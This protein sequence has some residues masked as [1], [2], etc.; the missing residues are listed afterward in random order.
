[1]KRIYLLIISLFIIATSF[2][3]NDSIIIEKSTD[4]VMIGGELYYV[5]IVKKGETLFS[6]SRVY[7]VSQKDIA[8]DNPE[9]FL[10]L[11]LG[12]A[13]KIPI[14][15]NK[16]AELEDENSFTYHKV[17]KGQTLYS[18]SKKYNVAQEDIIAC[19]PTVRYGINIDQLIKI[20]KSKQIAQAMQKFPTAD[21]QNDTLRISDDFLYHTVQKKETVYS[22][23]RQYEITEDIL[24]E[25]NP[26]A[27]EGL[28]IDQVLKIPKVIAIE[29]QTVLFKQDTAK[30]DTIVFKERAT[31]A[32][33]DTVEKEECTKLWENNLEPY[34]VALM[35]PFY[36]EK[37]DEEFYIDSSEYNDDGEK[38]YERVYYSPYYIYPRSKRFIEFYEGILLSIDSLK[39]IGLSVNVNVYDTQNDTARVQEILLDP[40]LENMDL[41]IG[42]IYDH[43]IKL[44]SEFSKEH[45]IKMVSPLS[46]NLKFVD[47]NPYL[48]Q[49]YP[50][51][52]AQIEEFAKYVSNYQDQNIIVVHSG[53]SLAYE[54]IQMVKNRIFSY[55]S[56]DT[57]VNNIQFKEVVFKDSIN[58]L[59]HALDKEKLNLYVLP[60]NNEAFVTDVVTKLNTL[61]AFGSNVEV[62]GLSRWQRFD[63]IDPEYFFNLNLALATPFFIDYN[64]EDVKQFVLK[65]RNTFRTEPSQMAIHGYD[66]GLY[67]FSLLKDYGNNF[68]NCI[69]NYEIDLLQ[70]NYRF[71]KWYNNSGYENV[72]VDMI[73]YYDGYN[74]FRIQEFNDFIDSISN[75]NLE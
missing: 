32:Y 34:Q 23:V 39:Q 25:H 37:N 2:A 44:V 8:K 50:S 24:Y 40:E 67:F 57:I 35:L 20:P 19:N 59:E 52:E 61:K 68:S 15:K 70:A 12:Q 51:H 71:V 31:I 54:N 13:L 47:N 26:T 7:E 41:I 43:E 5:H 56:V 58:A 42:P 16:D 46:D 65:Y 22:L 75:D 60:T 49:V 45:A 74:I 29:E 9:I 66:V 30:F 33:S 10:G 28:K 63:N 17:K 55:L 21:G 11:Q 27:K 48:Y 72:G 4:K 62:L 64:H 36:L 69:I 14:S 1:M 3:Q 53:D 73:K 38:I 18:L 6:I